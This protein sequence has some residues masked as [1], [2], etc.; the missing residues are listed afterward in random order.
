MIDEQHRFG[1]EQRRALRQ[2]SEIPPHLL[3]LTATPIPRT[4]ALTAYGELQNTQ[5]KEMPPG[6]MPVNTRVITLNQRNSAWAQIR[7][8][9]K[10]SCQAYVVCPLVSDSETEGF[11]DLKSVETEVEYLSKEIFPDFKVGLLHGKMKSE[12]KNRVM[13]AFKA[14]EIHILV[15]TTVIEVGVDVPNASIII[16]EHAERFGLSQL[17]QLRGRVGRGS[18]ASLCLL[19]TGTRVNEWTEKKIVD[20]G[21]DDRWIQDC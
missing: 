4:L 18:H 5:I 12:E 10:E 14:G 2:K 19:M 9:L 7:E 21:E 16:I 6:R 11:E 8:E 17:H 1:V 3:I 15:S 13:N 20:H